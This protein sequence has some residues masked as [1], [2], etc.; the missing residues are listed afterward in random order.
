MNKMLT[1]KSFW[2]M[3][4]IGLVV[5]FFVGFMVNSTYSSEVKILMIP[6]S[7]AVA[8]NI[9]QVISN[10]KEIPATL[11]FYG[12]LIQRNPN[13]EDTLANLPAAKKESAWQ[14]KIW[15]QRI[16]GSA[17]LKISTFAKTP[18]QAEALSSAVAKNIAVEL[19][20]YYDIK[21]ELETR[22]IDGPISQIKLLSQNIYWILISLLCAFII[23][24]VSFLISTWPKTEKIDQI[25]DSS[26]LQNFSTNPNTKTEEG[27]ITI[28][29]RVNISTPV[30]NEQNRKA[31]APTNLPIAEGFMPEETLAET[32]YFSQSEPFLAQ[33]DSDFSEPNFEEEIQNVYDREATHT[34]IKARFNKL[35]GKKSGSQEATPEEIKERLNKLL[36][37]EF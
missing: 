1:S 17:I 20:G 33:A 16:N 22:I 15:I 35:Q 36:R 2:I 13:I 34:E 25:P 27:S 14:S 24:A 18:W 26:T 11:S 19:S 4:I 29:N 31:A 3:A 28:T 9:E 30:F 12:K 5:V 37:G 21:N 8:K 7:E 6:K 32:D 23:G 10:A